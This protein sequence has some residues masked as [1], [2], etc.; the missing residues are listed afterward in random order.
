MTSLHLL[1]TH[2]LT[3]PSTQ[4]AVP[5][6]SSFLHKCKEPLKLLA[7]FKTR[8]SLK[9]AAVGSFFFRTY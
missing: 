4:F 9:D 6:I 5:A 1:A 7:D 2:L 3:W 8:L